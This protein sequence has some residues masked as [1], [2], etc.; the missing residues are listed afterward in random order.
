VAPEEFTERF[1]VT[2]R[3]TA[4]NLS[5]TFSQAKPFVSSYLVIVR[6]CPKCPQECYG[7]AVAVQ[8]TAHSRIEL[9]S[10]MLT[11]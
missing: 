9:L 11:R 4:H 7:A 10:E 3:R 6:V 5:V 1:R 2:L 8:S